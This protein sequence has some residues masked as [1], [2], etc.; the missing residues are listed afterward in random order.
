MEA[1]PVNPVRNTTSDHASAIQRERELVGGL[2]PA[3]VTRKFFSAGAPGIFP[4]TAEMSNNMGFRRFQAKERATPAKTSSG[5]V[6]QVDWLHDKSR[7]CHSKLRNA[8]ND[9]E[10]I[11]AALRGNS[12]VTMT[13]FDPGDALAGP[14]S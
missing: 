9:A 14:C 7:N 12:A 8:R 5:L 13:R 10:E 3:G 4:C 2:D 6:R 1:Y 11:L